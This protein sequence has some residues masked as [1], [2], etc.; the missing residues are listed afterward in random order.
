[1]NKYVLNKAGN[2][3]YYKNYNAGAWLDNIA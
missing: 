2:G 1:M 3:S